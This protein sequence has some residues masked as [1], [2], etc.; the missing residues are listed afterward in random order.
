MG[1]HFICFDRL[2]Y[3]YFFVGPSIFS[4]AEPRKNNPRPLVYISMGTVINDRPD[5]YAK[6]FDALKYENVE[7]LLS[8]GNAIDVELLGRAFYS[9][10]GIRSAVRDLLDNAEYAQAAEEC[11][12]DLR[13]CS[14]AAGAADFI[15]TAPHDSNGFG[16]INALNRASVKFRIAYWAAAAALM[17]FVGA[18]F[19]WKYCWLVGIP[20]GILS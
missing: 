20:A 13:S 4:K 7:V 6:C 11:S 19:G 12:R 16:V 1:A 18:L 8:C 10:A 14:G 15:E 9:A 2:T 5:L 3:H 17:I